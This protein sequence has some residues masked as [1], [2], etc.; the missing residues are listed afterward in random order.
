MLP[1]ELVALKERTPSLKYALLGQQ[2]TAATLEALLKVRVARTSI[3]I[4]SS[5]TP[6]LDSDLEGAAGFKHSAG[7]PSLDSIVQHS[8][9]RDCL[10]QPGILRVPGDMVL[11][12]RVLPNKHGIVV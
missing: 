10:F 6:P 1:A 11:Y 3:P 9:A 5:S 8:R 2:I 12:D 4:W 7:T